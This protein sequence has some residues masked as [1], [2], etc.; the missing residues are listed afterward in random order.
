MVLENKSTRITFHSFLCPP[1]GEGT[2]EGDGDADAAVEEVLG[3]TFGGATVRGSVREEEI[4]G[5]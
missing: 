2:G 3:R 1:R 4:H 5:G